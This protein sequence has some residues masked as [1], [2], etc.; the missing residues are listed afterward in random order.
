M[1][2]AEVMSALSAHDA[3]VVIEGQRIRVLHPAGHPP[4]A[5]LVEAARHHRDALWSLLESERRD[6]A[7]PYAKVLDALRSTCPELIE[8]VRWQQAIQDADSFIAKWGAQA[9]ALGWTARDLFGL[10]SVPTQ[11]APTYQRLARYDSTGLI[12]L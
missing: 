4:P 9:Q 12:W 5:E 7:S 3:S 10:H 8:A 11:P 2:A 1:N 6:P